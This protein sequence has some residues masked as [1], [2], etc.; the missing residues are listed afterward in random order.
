L[1]SRKAIY[2]ALATV[3]IFAAG[4]VTGGLLV[5]KIQ[6]R[7]PPGA[8]V[9][10]LGR[11]EAISRITEQLELAPDQRRRVSE[12]LRN[13][14]EQI[15]D[16]FLIL[17]PDIQHVFREMRQQIQKE[18]TGAQRAEFEKL[19]RQRQQRNLERRAGNTGSPPP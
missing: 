14:R 17:E 4:V 9:P 13:S 16:Y 12:I 10:F 6:P 18:L 7:P 3:V 11:V 8:R 5:N 19:L 2:V 1:N 15:A